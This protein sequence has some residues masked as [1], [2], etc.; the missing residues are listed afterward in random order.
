MESTNAQAVSNR[1]ASVSGKGPSYKIAIVAGEVSGDL[2]GAGLMRELKRRLPA[3][4]FLGIGGTH[5]QAEGCRSL[6]VMDRL[7]VMGLEDIGKIPTAFW[8]RRRLG[9]YLLAERPDLYIGVDAPDFNLAI[10]ERLHA[11]GIP[12]IHYVSP[13][14]WAWRGYRI[15]KIKRAVERMLTLF[16][17]EARYYEEHR[18]PVSFVGHPLA[19][20]I[21]DHYDRAAIRTRLGLPVAGPIVALLPGSR[22]GELKRHAMLFVRA[23]QW[24]QARHPNLHYVAPFASRSTQ[25]IFEQAL[26]RANARSLPIT[27]LL[28]QSRDALAACDVALLASGTATLEAALLKKPMVVTYKVSALSEVLVK[29]FVRVKMYALPNHLAG[30]LLVPEIMQG[31]ATPAAL[32]AAVE[33]YLE[34]PEQA[35]SVQAALAEMHKALKQNADARAAEAV[36]E[37]LIEKY[38]GDSAVEA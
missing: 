26:A 20:Q 11:T 33:Q 28:H 19:D 3:V 36:M 38:L 27:G 12:T 23:A 22:I 1:S 18:V 16:P 34:H 8:I 9:S 32:G 30:R 17:F 29:L 35:E 10:E 5:M 2:L 24:L 25:L 31:A 37:V 15:R 14:V 4:Q 6:Y 13:T 21:P 7:S